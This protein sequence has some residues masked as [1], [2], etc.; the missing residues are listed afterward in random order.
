M[1]SSIFI[2]DKNTYDDFK[3]IPTA[4]P[5]V[6]AAKV[7]TSFVDVSGTDGMLDLT[8]ALTGDVLYSNR[9]GQWDFMAANR[10]QDPRNL[11]HEAGNYFNGARMR[12]ILED[13][14]NYYYM[15]RLAIE[16]GKLDRGFTRITIKYILDPYKYDITSSI[17]DWLWDP[18]N[19]ETGIIREYR[20]MIVN[21][22]L[23]LKVPGSARPYIPIITCSAAMTVTFKNH[24]YSLNS[25]SNRITNILIKADEET[26]VFSG[27]GTVS[28]DY[29]GGWL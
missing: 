4:R 10:Y 14:P 29:R 25:G 16:P 20:D 8:T 12:V 3:I 7:K 1:Y 19:F 5:V 13:E 23:V 17:D 18:F 11:L 26:L 27:S 15:G 6:A 21:S 24:V 28:V 9:E 22:T 2:G